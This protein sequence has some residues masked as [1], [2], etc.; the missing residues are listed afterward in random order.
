[1]NLVFLSSLFTKFELQTI[2]GCFK[3]WTAVILRPYL[4]Q[5]IQRQVFFFHSAQ[6]PRATRVMH[7]T[8]ETNYKPTNTAIKQPMN[9]KFPKNVTV[10][11][12]MYTGLGER[13]SSATEMWHCTLNSL[14]FNNCNA[15][16]ALQQLHCTFVAHVLEYTHVP[17]RAIIIF[18]LLA[19]FLC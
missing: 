14:Y 13:C 12:Q 7:V 6:H 1:M 9:L 2:I 8:H 3:P 11:W 17:A 18:G 5:E 4:A 15:T 10:Y 19:V 16:I